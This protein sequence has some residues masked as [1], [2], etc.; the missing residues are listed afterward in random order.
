MISKIK[1]IYGLAAIL[2]Y[3]GQGESNA[4]ST[5]V[6]GSAPAESANYLYSRASTEYKDVI[7]QMFEWD[8]NSVA[9][10]CTNFLGPAG[11]GYVQT[12]PANEHVNGSEWYTDYESV[13][14]NITSKRGSRAEFKAM[15]KTCATAGVG[16]IADVVWNHMANGTGG[17]G[18]NGSE[19]THYD[20]P[21]I[22]SA[23]NFHHCGLEANDDIV[24]YTSRAE[25]QTC[26][27]AGLADLATNSSFVQDR[28]AKYGDDLISLG[29]DGFRLDA[30][31]HIPAKDIAAILAAMKTKP[32]FVT[33][34]V[35]YGQGEPITPNEYTRNGDVLEPRYTTELF[36][37]FTT[38]NLS[39][40]EVL[41]GR[42]WVKSSKA[43]T[44]VV[45]PDT[46][47]NGESLTFNST[48]NTFILASVFNLAH[49]YGRPTVLSSYY[50]ADND[51][52]VGAPNNGTGDC[53]TNSGWI[54]QH[55][56][57]QIVGMVGFRNNV[58]N[59]SHLNNFVSGTSAQIAFGRGSAGHVAINNADSEWT[60]TLKTSLE[61]G[62]YCDVVG[63]YVNSAG[64]GCSGTAYVLQIFADRAATD[65]SL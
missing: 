64:N 55:R 2:A 38:G 60:V 48:N 28:L 23:E 21:G 41:N 15:V 14:Y 30:A 40:L 45:S 65:T 9:D 16:V 22:Y 11:Y 59:S 62:S 47:R 52:S 5:A 44:F 27:L 33:Q 57:L 53:E 51:T 26:Q 37:A 43:N 61:D 24:N 10:E 54:C 34:D 8:W 42:G 56:Q 58:K 29:V 49:P 25:V 17:V 63:G 50:F 12:S 19:F 6:S 39:G 1:D 13:T 35:L 18:V 20:Y 4:G 46:E 32:A 36:N 3:L 7:A 31:T